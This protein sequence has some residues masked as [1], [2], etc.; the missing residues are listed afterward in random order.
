MRQ[1][2]RAVTVAAISILLFGACSAG[3][4]PAPTTGGAASPGA[5]ESPAGGSAAPPSSS[6]DP[7]SVTGTVILSGWQSTG[8]EGDALQ[9]T[10]DAFEAA[11]PN[12]TLD[13]QPVATDYATAMAAKFSAGEP[14]DLFYVDSFVSQD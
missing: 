7:Q 3:G 9:A 12:I 2:V 5:S 14:P 10:L 13:Y 11:Y 4:T 8:A 6:W 1:P